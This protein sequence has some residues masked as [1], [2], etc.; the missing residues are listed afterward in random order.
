ME[1][2]SYFYCY[3]E[4]KLLV[5]VTQKCSGMETAKSDSCNEN[6]SKSMMKVRHLKK[7]L[8]CKKKKEKKRKEKKTRQKLCNFVA[9]LNTY[10]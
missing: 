9:L 7:K 10:K 3:L 8:E 6:R 2:F 5:L 4:Q 1:L